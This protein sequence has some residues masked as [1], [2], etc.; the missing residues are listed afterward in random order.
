MMPAASA[1]FDASFFATK[2]ATEYHYAEDNTI[3]LAD[4]LSR[5]IDILSKKYKKVRVVSHSLGC[6]LLLNAVNNLPPESR[7][8]YIHMCAPSF[9]EDEFK[10]SLDDVAKKRT[11]IYYTDSDIVLSVI[12]KMIR[13]K[14][15]VGAFGL[16][17]QYK[18][19]KT[20]D[21]TKYFSNYFLTHSAYS[22]QFDKMVE[23]EEM[24]EI[25][26]Y[27]PSSKIPKYEP[28]KN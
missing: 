15:P 21:V 7:P 22:E 27:I 9:S 4:E 11:F 24:P 3:K 14:N 10:D 5:D 6:K 23:V 19:V 20:I 12:L 25:A 18:N 2:L 26:R 28:I 17:G 16:E 8:D 13:S 1:A